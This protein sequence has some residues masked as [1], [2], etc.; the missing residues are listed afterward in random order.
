MNIFFYA[1][2]L[3]TNKLKYM[4]DFER[5]VLEKV[6]EIPRG[7]ITTYKE[8]ARALCR[9]KAMRAVGGALRKN[10]R[11]V[12]V[13]CHRVIRSGGRLG[14]YVLGGREKRRLLDCEGVRVNSLGV[15]D[16]KKYLFEF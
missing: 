16:V 1:K 13:P 10:D 4:T 2:I 7:K 12:E 3:L 6:K 14:G 9:P 15:V 11:L 5:K 8:L